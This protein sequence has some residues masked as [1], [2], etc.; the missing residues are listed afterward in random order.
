MDKEPT[1]GRRQRVRSDP[2]VMFKA[3]GEGAV[4]STRRS[5]AELPAANEVDFSFPFGRNSFSG[6]SA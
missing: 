3:T 2:A 4:F 6:C 5:A 1:I